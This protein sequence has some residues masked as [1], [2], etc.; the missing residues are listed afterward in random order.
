LLK[1]GRIFLSHLRAVVTSD[2]FQEDEGEG[3]QEADRAEDV[4]RLA[5]PEPPAEREVV[6]G[7]GEVSDEDGGNA[8]GDLGSIS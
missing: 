5:P 2:A 8:I 1:C 6:A 7:V 4:P 3:E